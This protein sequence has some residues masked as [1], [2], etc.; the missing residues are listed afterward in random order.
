[1][2]VVERALSERM[3]KIVIIA[4]WLLWIVSDTIGQNLNNAD[5]L[6]MQLN[7]EQLSESERINLLLSIAYYHPDASTSLKYSFLG[8]D[9][10]IKANDLQLQAEAYEEIGAIQRLLGNNL[11]SMASSLKALKLFEQLDRGDL[12]AAVWAQLGANAANDEDYD[13]AVTYFHEAIITYKKAGDH[14][15]LALTNLNL[16]EA[17]RLN[18]KLDSA[19]FWF[20][21]ALLLNDSLNHP[22]VA[23]YALG[24]LGMTYNSQGRLSEAR[25]A[26]T[27]SLKLVKELGD[28]YTYAVYLADLGL[29]NQKEGDWKQAISDLSEALEIARDKGLKEQIRDISQMLAKLYKS[30]EDYAKAFVYQE[31]FQV[32]QDSLVNKVNVQQVERL[33]ANYQMDQ[34]EVEISYLTQINSRQKRE[35]IAVIG[36]MVLLVGLSFLLYQSNRQKVRA[37]TTLSLQKEL[38]TKKEEEKAL[39]LKELNH[40]VKNNLQMISSL[41]NLQ[42]NELKGHP[43]EAAIAAGKYRVD[44]LAL[45][46]QKLYRE[47]IHTKIILKDYIEELVL[48]LCYS[49]GNKVIPSLQIENVSVSID[50]AIPLALII[51]ELVTNA[52]KYAFVGVKHPTL[53]V[54]LEINEQCLV[55]KVKDNGVGFTPNQPENTPSFGIKL[56]HSLI[57]Q[58]KADISHVND[59][60]SSWTIT[61]PYESQPFAQVKMITYVI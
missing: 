37:N 41:L 26:L 3:F 36:G 24:N 28:P 6:I 2:E 51:N 33:K 35:I 8:L 29:I 14:I 58:L 55:M 59:Q 32:Y 13:Q 47:E 56:V 4:F 1:M 40:R 22:I 20:Q 42:G 30:K 46:H 19:V 38:I 5:S 12:K 15:L 7:T 61:L 18:G 39:L 48:N 11:E 54:T 31:L 34:K 60:G 49:F 53:K 21:E 50:Q 27:G 9:L 25:Q 44:A 17:Y 57:T 45:I 16:G 23:S 43:A 52:L 10:A